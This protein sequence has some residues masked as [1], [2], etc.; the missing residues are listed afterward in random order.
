MKTFVV[1]LKKC[2]GCHNC[3][4]ACKDEHCG[5]DWMPYAKPQPDTGQFWLKLEQK[6]RGQIPQVKVTYMAKMCQ[7]CSNASCMQACPNGAI[8][9]RDDGIVWIDPEKCQGCR[10]CVAACPYDCIF[11]N[12]EFNLAQKCTGCAHLLDRGWPISE[13][14]CVNN[15]HVGALQFG[16]ED[17]LDLEGA[18][19][20]HAE[21]GTQP[22]VWYKNLPKKFV[23]GTVYDPTKNEVVIGAI[24]TLDGPAGRFVEE[25]DHFGDF[26]FNDLP[27][28][29][30]TLT[31]NSAGKIKEMLVSTM[32]KDIGLGDI[33]LT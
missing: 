23:A 26:W 8:M 25:T 32:D 13:P 3:Q 4:V 7:Q 27:D 30:F 15:C 16:E 19:K 5:N 20:L 11:F 29:E 28:G 17:E 24:C 9:R 12:E 22:N 14:R 6:E 1:D 2:V 18:E 21:Y 10:A 31:I 33:P